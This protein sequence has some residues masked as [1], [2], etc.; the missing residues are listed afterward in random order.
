MPSGKINHTEDS[1]L[2]NRSSEISPP[3]ECHYIPKAHFLNSFVICN[4]VNSVA[5]VGCSSIDELTL[6]KYPVY[7]GFDIRTKT[8][9]KLKTYFSKDK[10]KFFKSYYSLEHSSLCNHFDLSISAGILENLH[11][12]EQYLLFL[13]N[14]FSISKSF[15]IIVF[16]S[17]NKKTTYPFKEIE[18]I[19]HLNEWKLISRVSLDLPFPLSKTESANLYIYCHND[20]SKDIIIPNLSS[21][22]PLNIPFSGN[23]DSSNIIEHAISKNQVGKQSTALEKAVEHLRTYYSPSMLDLGNGAEHLYDYLVSEIKGIRFENCDIAITDSAPPRPDVK[24]KYKTYDGKNLPFPDDSFDLVFC[25]NVLGYVHNPEILFTEINRVLKP[26]GKVIGQVAQIG[27]YYSR[28]LW[29]ITPYGLDYLAN[30]TGLKVEH[31]YPGVDIWTLLNQSMDQRS[32][33]LDPRLSAQQS[34]IHKSIDQFGIESDASPL[35]INYK[36]LLYSGQFVFELSR[37]KLD[38]PLVVIYTHSLTIGGLQRVAAQT[39]QAISDSGF[40]VIIVQQN[41]LKVDYEYSGKIFIDDINNPTLRSILKKSICIIDFSWKN[42]TISPFLSYSLKHYF[43]KFVATAHNTKTLSSYLE[44]I[45]I[46][47][48]GLDNLPAV[49]C[50]S[51]AV[52]NKA[53]EQYGFNHHYT[54]IHNSFAFSQSSNISPPRKRPYFLF[55]GRIWAVEHKGLD[56]LLRAWGKSVCKSTH[57]LILLGDGNLSSDLKSIL[58]E[59]DIKSSVHVEAFSTDVSTW[60]KHAHML[61]L[62]S[63]WEGFGL[64]LI[65]ALSCGT[66]CITTRC[67]G[68]EEI[69]K[70][71]YNGLLVD[72][73]DIEGLQKAIDSTLADTLLYT[74]MRHNAKKSIKQ[75]SFESY[76]KKWKELVTSVASKAEAHISTLMEPSDDYFYSQSSDQDKIPLTPLNGTIISPV[77][78]SVLVP[79]YNNEDNLQECL[80][81]ILAQNFEDF[82]VICIDDCSTD[83]SLN[84][85]RSIKK[86]DPRIKVVRNGKSQGALHTIIRGLEDS[87]G[88]YACFVNADD[89]ISP[90]MLRDLYEKAETASADLVQ[91]DAEIFE[92]ANSPKQNDDIDGHNL[93]FDDELTLH[94]SDILNHLIDQVKINLLI[95]FVRKD[96]YK[97]I[98]PYIPKEIILHGEENLIM[99]LLAY[100]SQK[101]ATLNKSLYIYRTK[102]TCYNI[103]IKSSSFITDNILSRAAVID[104]IKNIMH[105]LNPDWHDFTSPFPR[106]SDEI[107]N[108]CITLSDRCIKKYPQKKNN[109]LHCLGD[110]FGGKAA[111][112]AASAPIGNTS[113]PAKP[114]TESRNKN[115][116]KQ[117]RNNRIE[118]HTSMLANIYPRLPVWVQ[119]AWRHLKY[120]MVKPCIEH[121]RMLSHFYTIMRSNLFFSEYYLKQLSATDV[122][123]VKNPLWHF[124]KYGSKN[125][126]RPN[127]LFSIAWY[128]E[129]NPEIT[130][131]G[132]SLLV[133]YI[134]HGWKEKRSPSENFSI[135]E[136]YNKRPDLE[137]SN[138]EPLSFYLKTGIVE[139]LNSD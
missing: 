97:A 10:L 46:A 63:R 104:H 112:Y 94:G 106:F 13:N 81:S 11:K 49:V 20:C 25:N 125:N 57:D 45:N 108:Y 105:K 70:D 121:L 23:Q 87:V 17:K 2:S 96:V 68:P 101:Y 114:L 117:N 29:S 129:N 77:S 72:I 26:D 107:F 55:V 113:S 138:I 133:H 74:K 124:I 22:T 7:T 9:E 93:K 52:K 115:K 118:I 84:I 30:Q 80:E 102:K 136:F 64:V 48:N 131:D 89:K 27:P 37:G 34:P 60:M 62:P 73:E 24:N 35:H 4:N 109:I 51:E 53:I 18:I 43:Y 135:K 42:E 66:P 83:N 111:I 119:K 127:P 19:D 110:A 59:L 58:N 28:N 88:K 139:E 61:L 99:Y 50:V 47:V 123:L 38:Q 56:I 103:D 3:W 54:V 44:A 100:F 14:L 95:S 116:T 21:R 85:L 41:D 91:C 76:T 126:L 16:D 98:I 69:I 78:V 132:A 65:E 82:E 1:L 12:D 134:R 40:S 39:S 75:F 36:K 92:V 137:K 120:R 130:R 8:I 31:L 67:G 90:D 86:S 6:S 79:V 33:E 5:E 122:D 128:K 15:V 71:K 32:D